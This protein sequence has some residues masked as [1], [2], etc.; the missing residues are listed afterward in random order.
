MYSHQVG[1]SGSDTDVDFILVL[2]TDIG[3]HAYFRN[4]KQFEFIYDE[5]HK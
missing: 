5:V 3:K 4:R 2:L 1:V